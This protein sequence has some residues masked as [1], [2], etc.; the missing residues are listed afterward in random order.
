VSGL[1]LALREAIFAFCDTAR[2]PEIAERAAA[3]S[4]CYRAGGGSLATVT[5]YPD[6]AAYLTARLPA[7]FAAAGAAFAAVRARAPDFRPGSMLDFGAGPGTASWAA[8]ETWPNLE[9]VMM[10]DHNEQFLRAARTLS[11][12][13]PHP[14]LRNATISNSQ[15]L[16]E[17]AR[18][19]LVVA[20]FVMCELPEQLAGEI[21]SRLWNACSGLLV[22][23]EPGTPRAF[24]RILRCRQEL[25]ARNAIIAAPC[26][27]NDPC[28]MQGPDWCHFA[29]RLPRTRD[30]MRAK[31]ASVPYE[32]E[33]FSYV[34]AVREDVV[35]S[36][37]SQRIIAPV[38]SGKA[39]LK[40]RVCTG[41]RIAEVGVPRREHAVYRQS[42][43][44]RWGGTL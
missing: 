29:V 11:D 37:S 24:Q 23:V 40:F 38:L 14:A 4:A 31:N 16:S 28:P 18:Y 27:A 13:S 20:A 6:V 19:E 12:N 41:D 35:L 15:V 43:R 26:P 36:T 5:D 9:S 8:V 17:T 2:G 44:K 1:P 7:T 10:T 39:G 30:H 32:D 25:C 22:I 42:T 33:R 21:A 34:A 3:Q